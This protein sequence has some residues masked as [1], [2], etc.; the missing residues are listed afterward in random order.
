MRRPQLRRG[1][2]PNRPLF[3]DTD[4]ELDDGPGGAEFDPAEDFIPSTRR[5]RSESSESSGNQSKRARV[6]EVEDEDSPGRRYYESYPERVADVLG[7]GVTE[8][9]DIRARQASSSAAEN[10]WSPF[11]DEE[12]WELAEWLMTETTQKARDKFL[13][14]PIVSG[15]SYLVKRF[16]DSHVIKTK[17]R[18]QT[19]YSSAYTLKNKIDGLPIGPGWTCEMVY[20]TGND[21][22]ADGTYKVEELELWR[23]DPVECM[24]DLMGNPAFRDHISYVPERAFE[25]EEGQSRVY[26]EMWSG[27]WW[28]KTQVRLRDSPRRSCGRVLITRNSLV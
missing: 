10:P 18:T 22:Q 6:E 8:F 17:N 19:S 26:D 16:V 5:P 24:K 7:E 28:W 15:H 20:Q 27:D 25:D 23:R 11:R 2:Q 4:R 21:K 14:L 12:E 9:E 13:K 1:E 3:T